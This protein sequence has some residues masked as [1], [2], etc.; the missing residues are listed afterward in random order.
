MTLPARDRRL[1]A[2]IYARFST[3]KQRETSIEDQARLGKVRIEAEEWEFTRLY[4]DSQTSGASSFVD[5]PDA[6]RL[7]ADIAGGLIDVVVFE[8]LQ[9]PFRDLVDQETIVRRLEFRGLL[10][11]GITDGYDTRRED[12]EMMR[13]VHGGM[14]ST[15]LRDIGRKVHRGLVGQVA[16]GYH[17]GGISYGYKSVVAGVDAHGVPIGHRLEIDEE[18]ARWVRWIFQ[19]Y[20]AGVS[21][22]RIASELNEL[23]VPAPG[24]RRRKIER[25]TWCVSAIYGCPLKGSGIINN[26]I[27]VGRYIWNRSKWSRDPDPPRK[28]VRFERPRSEWK[29][30][31]RPD[32]RII[33]AE[34]WSKARARMDKPA[35]AGGTRGAGRPARTL[36]GGMLRCGKCGGAVVAINQSAYGCAAN[37]D[38]GRSVCTGVQAPRLAMDQ[39]LLNRVKEDITAPATLI[40]LRRELAALLSAKERKG[41]AGEFQKRLRG[42]QREIHNLTEAVASMGISD[43]LRARLVA[44]E[45]EQKALQRSL[46]PI[47]A[48]KPTVDAVMAGY[49]RMLF[50]LREALKE[51]PALARP[52]LHQI[53]G[54]VR[55]LEEGDA[56][57]AEIEDPVQRLLIAAA[58]GSIDNSGCGDMLP[59]FRQVRRIRIK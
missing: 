19:Q 45:N 33:D 46:T 4:S 26:E 30:E 41:D 29:I 28:R 36:F 17:A 58:G 53:L 42:V 57:Y 25:A 32:L 44:A 40:E 54:D 3:D 47:A 34:T 7:L 14:N 1:R 24:A 31:E 38:R 11:I 35:S 16:R 5:R 18:H 23:Q 21:C 22:Q 52:I 2:A 15:Q 13:I 8:S 10:I 48:I 51:S 43:A 50:D 9:R 6:A 49:K 55:V 20:V 27:Y 59:E 56:V 37:K 39:R 12:R